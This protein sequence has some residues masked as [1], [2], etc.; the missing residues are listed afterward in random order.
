M[1]GGPGTPRFDGTSVS[2]AP[3]PNNTALLR[4]AGPNPARLLAAVANCLSASLLFALRKFRNQ[5][6]PIT[7]AATTRI[8]RNARNRL[9]IAGIAVQIRTGGKGAQMEHLDRALAQFEEFCI[10]TQSV[11][12][13]I[14]VAVGRRRGCGTGAARPPELSRD[15]RGQLPG[16]AAG[17]QVVSPWNSFSR[18]SLTLNS[19][20]NR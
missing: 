11:R 6:E 16:R 15:G 1:C 12:D 10:V 7:A 2:P 14:P 5:P 20:S 19:P 8:A 18:P 3:T 9:R 13:G 4:D 17:P